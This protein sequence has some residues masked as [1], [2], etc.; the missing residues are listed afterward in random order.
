MN[1]DTIP[2]IVLKH[3]TKMKS[4]KVLLLL[5]FQLLSLMALAQHPEKKKDIEEDDDEVEVFDTLFLNNKQILIGE[6]KMVAQGRAR[7]DADQIDVVNIELKNIKTIHATAHSYRIETIQRE[8][9][10]SDI[11]PDKK[12][13]GFVL[14]HDSTKV[15][16]IKI[17]D[18]LKLERLSQDKTGFW[19][20]AFA[21]GYIYS[22]S[23]DIGLFNADAAL[24]YNST[25]LE[26]NPF[27]AVVIAQI[28]NKWYRSNETGGSYAYYNINSSWQYLGVLAYQRNL[29][30][31][32]ARRFQEGFGAAYKVVTNNYLKYKTGSGL[33]LNQERS[34]ADI[35]KKFQVE[36]P[37]LN[38]I[39]LYHFDDPEVSVQLIQN[40][41]FSL[42]DAGRI[43]HDGQVK[44]NWELLD[45]LYAHAAFYDYY[46]NKPIY[47]FANKLDLGV[48]FGF[49]Y[50]FSQ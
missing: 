31:G 13:D 40:F 25:K 41:Y 37:W 5:A 21:L 24:N 18:I 7:I 27:Y 2:F 6:L 49:T 19:E 43:R 4:L 15:R 14:L 34:V 35:E 30:L 23:S 48:L 10:I 46:D 11:K 47:Q 3:L 9:F 45:D 32:L 1:I 36:I 33:V 20:G 17:I 50:T 28:N 22:R 26:I 16:S 39:E 29:R 12:H 44:L 38:I 8:T 42:T